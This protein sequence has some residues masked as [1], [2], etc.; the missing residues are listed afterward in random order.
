[1]LRSWL[2]NGWGAGGGHG[3]RRSPGLF[4]FLPSHFGRRLGCRGCRLRGR[5]LW[6]G[7]R[8][9]RCGIH[10]WGAVLYGVHEVWLLVRLQRRTGA[11][12]RCCC[13]DDPRFWRRVG[14]QSEG[15]RRLEHLGVCPVHAADALV[16]I[17]LHG[18][19]GLQ[20]LQVLL[21]GLL[22]A[23]NSIKPTCSRRM[24]THQRRLLF[25][26]RDPRERSAHVETPSHRAGRARSARVIGDD[27]E[28]RRA[29]RTGSR[30]PNRHGQRIV[31]CNLLEQ[32]GPG[33]TQ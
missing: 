16:A 21:A 28:A 15:G 10:Q 1:M 3:W 30:G 31:P 22:S 4:R 23:P 20:E 13:R 9:S 17:L 5:V 7:R 12:Q 11:H 6:W 26:S 29:G 2:S 27:A 24:W 25:G 19:Q 8:G 32:R 18:I 14:G 33:A